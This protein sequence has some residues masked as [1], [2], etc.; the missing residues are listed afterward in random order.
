TL[1]DSLLFGNIDP[2]GT[3]WSGGEAEVMSAV[4]RAKEA[5][6][7]AVWPGCDL[8]PQTSIENLKAFI[9]AS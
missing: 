3:L 1:T 6:V 9:K 4:H 2:A 7:N 8:V 5:G